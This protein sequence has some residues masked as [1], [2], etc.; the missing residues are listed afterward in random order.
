MLFHSP[1]EVGEYKPQ[2]DFLKEINDRSSFIDTK[3]EKGYLS[4]SKEA[5]GLVQQL[6]IKSFS[7][8]EKYFSILES[9]SKEALKQRHL[10]KKEKG[11]NNLFQKCTK[12]INEYLPEEISDII[13]VNK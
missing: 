11:N 9:A 1:K 10:N 4:I 6:A 12:E 5:Q 3:K 2:I 7:N 8:V 13:K